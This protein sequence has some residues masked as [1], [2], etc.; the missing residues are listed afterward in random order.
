M[1][2]AVFVGLLVQAPHL[3]P[4][5]AAAC[6]LGTAGLFTRYAAW[7]AVALG[8]VSRGAAQP[9]LWAAALMAVA[10]CADVLALDAVPDAWRRADAR[11]TAPPARSCLY[12]APIRVLWLFALLALPHARWSL[13]PLLFAF[14]DWS[15]GFRRLGKALFTRP[16]TIVND[17]DCGFCRRAIAT[18]RTFDVLGRIDWVA[19]NEP[20]RLRAAGLDAIADAGEIEH[21]TGASHGEIV[22]GYDAYLRLAKR[23][24]LFW[25]ALPVLALPFVVA[26]G[27]AIYAKVEASRKD[28]N[29]EP[30]A[31]RPPTTLLGVWIVGFVVTLVALQAAFV[32]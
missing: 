16:L 15:A 17:G 3:G 28:I 5:Y 20:E 4:I 31:T 13:V 9:L 23:V 26:I 29:P 10:P 2:I 8:I 21:F 30:L 27:R 22:T 19:S 1:R 32:R 6:V 24:P 14:V 12:G 25:P 11:G 18:L 7:V